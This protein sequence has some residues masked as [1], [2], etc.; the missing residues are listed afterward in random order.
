MQTLTI[1]QPDD[2]H[3]H[4]R[5][6]HFLPKTVNDIARVFNRCVVMPNLE[7]PVCTAHDAAQYKERILQ[8]LS[9]SLTLNP[10]MTLYL[11]DKT[12]PSVIEEAKASQVVHACKLYPQG[13][14]T[15]SDKGVTQ[16]SILY[17]ALEMMEKLGVPLLVH[18]EVTDPNVD[19]F[20]REQRFIEE[21]L[22][23]LTQRFPNLKV[24]LEH[25]TTKDAVDFVQSSSALIAATITPHHLMYNR[26]AMLVGGIKPHYYC[27]PILK[28][29]S[30]QDALRE[31]AISSNPKFFLG[32]DSAPHAKSTK[33]TACGCAGVYSAHA[34][35]E[36]YTQIFEDLG[37]LDKLEAFSSHFGADFYNLPRN[38]KKVTLIKSPWVVP[39]NYPYG[40]DTL[41]PMAAGET[42]RWQ[43]QTI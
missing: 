25:I 24:V 33:E 42:L 39:M 34:A 10:L 21:I 5:D 14:T 11:T 1:N 8:A 36:L 23:P 29:K 37:A 12:T 3:I 19:V 13:A 28:R 2:M 16:I 31:A 41:V 30:H 4:L 38:T 26:N 27:L 15:H 32:T 18:G 17:P 40:T 20:D 9:P 35:L 6:L 7:T 43:I 22:A